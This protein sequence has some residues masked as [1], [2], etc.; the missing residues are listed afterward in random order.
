MVTNSAGNNGQSMIYVGAVKVA[1]G[2]T[3]KLVFQSQA[4]GTTKALGTGS[5][6]FIWATQV[7]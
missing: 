1:G 5:Q 6:T 4:T 2:T 7:A 3:V